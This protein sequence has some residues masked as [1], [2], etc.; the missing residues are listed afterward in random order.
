MLIAIVLM[1]LDVVTRH[2]WLMVGLVLLM[3]TDHPPTRDDNVKLGWGRAILGIASL[4]IPFLCFA[5]KLII[6]LK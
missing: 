4:S 3:G 5:P 1:M 6:V 2:L